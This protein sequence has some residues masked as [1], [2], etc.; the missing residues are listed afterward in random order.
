MLIYI[1]YS[2]T[3]TS[4]QYIHLKYI[5]NPIFTFG[6]ILCQYQD[7]KAYLCILFY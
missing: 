5:R 7:S 4:R 2:F 1:K 6:T 3:F